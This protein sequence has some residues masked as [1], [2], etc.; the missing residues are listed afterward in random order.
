PSSSMAGASWLQ[1]RLSGIVPRQ[2]RLSLPPDR[3][4]ID[5]GSA[6][7]RQQSVWRSDGQFRLE[8]EREIRVALGALHKQRGERL[9][10]K[11]AEELVQQRPFRNF[12]GFS[13]KFQKH[14]DDMLAG[15]APV[16]G[17]GAARVGY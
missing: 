16:V 3:F 2:Q 12:A 5:G 13:Q 9:P 15:A 7:T 11:G 6:R 10:V 8:P 1:P 17:T 4:R 14:R